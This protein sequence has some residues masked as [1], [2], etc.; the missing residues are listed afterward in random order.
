MTAKSLSWVAVFLACW[1]GAQTAYA[2][3][4]PQKVASPGRLHIFVCEDGP[5]A[6]ERRKAA[7]S[8]HLAFIEKY[9]DQL[10]VA[11]PLFDVDG[12]KLVGSV[13]VIKASDS[14]SAWRVLAADPN[15]G[16]GVWV[17]VRQQQLLPAAGQWIGGITW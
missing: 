13:Y 17:S 11:G 1:F 15:Y 2:I 6:A 8:A 4:R 12:K 9:H 14:E 3:E 10:V 16:A 7:L 5:L